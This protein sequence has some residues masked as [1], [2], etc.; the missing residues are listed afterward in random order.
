MWNPFKR[1]NR[2]KIALQGMVNSL[3][4]NQVQT[5]LE[6]CMDYAR[7]NDEEIDEVYIFANIEESIFPKWFYRINSKIVGAHE[8]NDHVKKKCDT[9]TDRQF[10]ILGIL[11]DEV[12]A[13]EDTFIDHKQEVPTRVKIQYNPKSNKFDVNI[14]YTKILTGTHVSP[15][16]L[17][18]QWMEELAK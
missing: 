11:S 8:L 15:H 14:D 7:W 13:M 16:R 4:D 2:K 12:I 10:E 18:E 9:S 6:A 1:R 5:M 17:L 3:I